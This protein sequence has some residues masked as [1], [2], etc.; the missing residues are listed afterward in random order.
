[1]ATHPAS[2]TATNH[3]LFP[4]RW[5]LWL[6]SLILLC[7]ACGGGSSAGGNGSGQIMPT[8]AS[9]GLKT[10]FGVTATPGANTSFA[11]GT[12]VHYNFT[13]KDPLTTVL[14]KMDGIPVPA[15]GTLTMNTDHQ[16]EAAIDNRPGNHA[17]EFRGTMADGSTVVKLSDYQAQGKYVFVD[18]SEQTCQGSVNQ[19]A[20]L[21]AHRAAL[22]AKGMEIVTVLVYGPYAGQFATSA[23]A[24]AWQAAYGLTFPV[25][26]DTDGAN[27]I[28]NWGINNTW[29]IE[30]KTTDFPSGY[31]INDKGVILYK[32]IGFDGPTIDAA[33]A[34]LYP[35]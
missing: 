31:I 7:Q 8:Q 27:A 29:S 22:K 19:A 4:L 16:F 6:S 32:F 11:V 23:D 2:H 28:Y 20:Y 34:V 26:T 24:A 1:M 5:L 12:V 3:G 35:G 15:S 18:F 21:Q 33:L 25:L 30:Y 9:Y 14:V 17:P 13:G 10:G